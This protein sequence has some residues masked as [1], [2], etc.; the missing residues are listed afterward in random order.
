MKTKVIFRKEFPEN[1][2]EIIAVFPSLA[3]DPNPYATCLCYAHLGQHG[4]VALDY[5]QDTFPA[6]TLEYYPL[7]KELESIG[8]DL[9]VAKRFSRKD[10]Q[11][12]IN[13]VNHA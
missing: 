3:G 10:L 5:L 6:R 7:M 1:G 11:A 9:Q 2:G 13:Q 8:Y 12:R 4:A